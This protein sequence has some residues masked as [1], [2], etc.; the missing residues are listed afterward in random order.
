MKVFSQIPLLYSGGRIVSWIWDF[1]DGDYDSGPLVSHLYQE[2]DLFNI[3][4]YVKSDAGC[5]DSV[6]KDLQI[7][8]VPEADFEFYPYS[9]LHYLLKLVFL[10]CQ[11]M[12]PQYFGVLMMVE[13]RL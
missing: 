7:F 13:I 2:T 5:E 11:R 3:N 8:H 10:I 6:S 9:A 1:G 4:L 12:L